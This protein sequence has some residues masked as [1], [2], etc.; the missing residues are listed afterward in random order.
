MSSILKRRKPDPT[1][2]SRCLFQTDNEIK[3]EETCEHVEDETLDSNV[4][5]N[6]S[7]VGDIFLVSSHS[8]IN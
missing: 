5:N 8:F 4:E 1:A 7:E 3:E 6:V 2:Q